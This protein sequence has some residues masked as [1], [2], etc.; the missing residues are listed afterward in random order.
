MEM[1]SQRRFS[2]RCSSTPTIL[3]RIAEACRARPTEE[4]REVVLPAV[5]GGEQTLRELV[6][7]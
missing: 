5:R 4:V 1:S 3:F 7:G 2:F 6:H